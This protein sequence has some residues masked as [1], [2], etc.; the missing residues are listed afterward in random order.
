LFVEV[1]VECNNPINQA[2]MYIVGDCKLDDGQTKRTKGHTRIILSK[3]IQQSLKYQE[4]KPLLIFALCPHLKT[5][6]SIIINNYN[7]EIVVNNNLVGSLK[8]A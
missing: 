2:Q 7:Y 1:I 8:I 4:Q 3:T 6:P 5:I